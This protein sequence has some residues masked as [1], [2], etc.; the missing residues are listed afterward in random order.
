MKSTCLIILCAALLLVSGAGVANSDVLYDNL[1]TP[2]FTDGPS[3]AINE[4]G[5][6]PL[7]A[8][9]STGAGKFALTDVQ[10]AF[11]TYYSVSWSYGPVDLYS[12]VNVTQSNGTF[13]APGS[14][15][16][17]LG[18]FDELTSEGPDSWDFPLTTPYV[19]DANTRYWVVAQDTAHHSSGSECWDYSTTMTATGVAG[20]FNMADGWISPNS[21]AAYQMQISGLPLGLPL[22]PEPATIFFFGGGLIGLIAYRFRF[23]QV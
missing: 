21:T 16:C 22:V 11:Y 3:L 4:N 15:L 2:G 14:F 23:K 13:P 9:F 17:N 6:G 1:N 5:D 10:V 12:S 19:L 8:S 7:G 20:E 18:F